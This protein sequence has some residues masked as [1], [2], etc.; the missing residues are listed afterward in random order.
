MQFRQ[1]GIGFIGIVLLVLILAFFLLFGLR[2][3]PLYNEKFIVIT[4]M[5]N[6]AKKPGSKN[7]SIKEIRRTFSKNM[8]IANVDRF[9]DKSLNESVNLE[10]D[11]KRRFLHVSY[12]AKNV[13]A[14]DIALLLIFDRKVELGVAP[15]EK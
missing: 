6:I 2:L 15:I 7:L 3:F 14:K 12:E 13:L 9:T 5:D 1:Q 11:K 10:K 4:A 8:D